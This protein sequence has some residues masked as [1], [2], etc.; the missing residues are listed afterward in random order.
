MPGFGYSASSGWE[1]FSD[2]IDHLGLMALNFT[3]TAPARAGRHPFHSATCP[4]S[5]S[6]RTAPSRSKMNADETSSPEIPE[7]PETPK[8]PAATETLAELVERLGPPPPEVV[9]CWCNRLSQRPAGEPVFAGDRLGREAWTEFLVDAAGHLQPREE[10]VSRATSDLIEEDPIGSD[11][12]AVWIESLSG[13]LGLT[14]WVMPA[15]E[16]SGP[17]RSGTAAPLPDDSAPAVMGLADIGLADIKPSS[18]SPTDPTG[19]LTGQVKNRRRL[20]IGVASSIGVAWFS[21]SLVPERTAS[22]VADQED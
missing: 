13:S 2:R 4:A 17:D 5:Q 20:W 3:E 19:P 16:T 11:R 10:N 22:P 8:T 18:R 12:R 14:D 9:R 7:P 1:K 15:I 6:P 21:W